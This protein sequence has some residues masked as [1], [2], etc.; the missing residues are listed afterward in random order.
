VIVTKYPLTFSSISPAISTAVRLSLKGGNTSTKPR[1]NRS[2]EARRKNRIIMVV[3][4]RESV[5]AVPVAREP[6]RPL[7]C[8]TVTVCPEPS[9]AVGPVRFSSSFS[10]LCR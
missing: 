4:L 8:F 5:V 3:K 9:T 10:P 1:N 2:P 7:P 6:A